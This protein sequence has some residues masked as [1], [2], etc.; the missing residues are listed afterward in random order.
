MEVSYRTNG[1]RK[2]ASKAARRQKELGAVRAKNFEKRI[3]E[4]LAAECL[5]DLRFLP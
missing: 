2:L 4:L 3:S 1:L 5:E